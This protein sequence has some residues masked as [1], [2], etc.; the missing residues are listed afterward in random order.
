MPTEL[1][2]T[3]LTIASVQDIVDG[4]VT[5]LQS[6]YGADINVDSNSP[7]GQLINIFAQAAGDILEVLLDVY[8][9]FSPDSAYGQVLDQRVAING[10][11]RRQGTYTTTPVTITVNQAITLP[12]LDQTTV[13]PFTIADNAGN[14]FQLVTS[15]VFS[16]SGSASLTFQA[17][18]IG[19]TEVTAN[20]ITN[21]VTTILGVTAINNPTTVGTSVGIAEE[22]DAQLRVRRIQSFA[23]ASTGPAD[24]VSAALLAIPD[25]TDAFVVENAT[26]SEVAGTPANSIWCIVTGGTDAEIAQAI[27]A[28][29]G[30]GCGQR[31]GNSFIVARP[32]GTSFTALWDTSISQPLYVKCTI[33]PRTAGQA[34]DTAL[35]ET[36]LA[37]MLLYKLGDAPTVGDVVNAM[38][39]LAP[40]GYLTDIGVSANGSDFF[41]VV[42]PT[43]AQYYYTT[44]A[45]NVTISS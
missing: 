35:L 37:T 10:I 36:E 39:T 24:A 2:P 34:F 42:Q 30:L 41:D 31:G 21:A 45:A 8:N 4:I 3:G 5:D 16:A 17:F 32:N 23:L 20:T 33:N 38:L 18:A 6:I 11:A 12:G 43:T 26:S 27:Y 9:S 29:K 13:T 40:T 19:P 22:T 7:D 44:L 15:H 14:Q 1:S 25:V 28:K